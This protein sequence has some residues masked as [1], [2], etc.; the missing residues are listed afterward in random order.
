[1]RRPYIIK[2]V[3]RA[4]VVL[5]ETKNSMT[6]CWVK[7]FYNLPKSKRENRTQGTTPSQLETRRVAVSFVDT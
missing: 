4:A 3:D 5:S 2:N 1:M 7:P 6:N